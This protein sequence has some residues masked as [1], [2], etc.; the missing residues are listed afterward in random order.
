MWYTDLQ[1]HDRRRIAW[2]RRVLAS[3]VTAEPFEYQ[4][5]Q[6]RSAHRTITAQHG[7]ARHGTA[8]HGRLRPGL[9]PSGFAQRPQVC[10]SALRGECATWKHKCTARAGTSS[11]THC[12]GTARWAK[13][14]GQLSVQ[15]THA[16]LSGCRRSGVLWIARSGRTATATRR[17]S[18]SVCSDSPKSTSL[19]VRC[20]A[21]HGIAGHG[22]A[23]HCILPIVNSSATTLSASAVRTADAQGTQRREL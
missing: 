1:R 3:K 6:P 5:L 16:E 2:C 11:L 7:T 15:F 9:A 21:L 20:I 18:A 22:I 19:I 14:C 10:L 8:Q 23:W 13:R 12:R 4:T 17:T